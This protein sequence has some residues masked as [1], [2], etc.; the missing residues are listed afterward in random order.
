MSVPRRHHRDHS[1]VEQSFLY[2]SFDIDKGTCYSNVPDWSVPSAG[3][4]KK[5]KQRT[6]CQNSVANRCFSLSF[7]VYLLGVGVK[8]SLHLVIDLVTVRHL[9]YQL[10]LMCLNTCQN[11]VWC[12][13]LLPIIF[14]ITI[15]HEIPEKS[16]EEIEIDQLVSL[17]F[18]RGNTREH[19]RWS[20]T[21]AGLDLG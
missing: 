12:F 6:T 17:T 9:T 18:V 3:K 11:F 15:V 1:T 16:D 8:G 13:L 2:F 19:Y 5:N 7:F 10:L 4:T 20:V 14:V 21:T